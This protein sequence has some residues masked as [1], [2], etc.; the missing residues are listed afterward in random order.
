MEVLIIASAAF[1]GAIIAALA[2][3]LDSQASF[4]VRKFLSSAL[5]AVLAAVGYA[6]VYHY[7]ASGLTT[8]DV[9]TAFLGG[10]GVDV[11]GNRMTGYLVAKLGR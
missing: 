3:Y 8:L 7:S 1:A 10:A 6:V 2:G 9:A 11:L 5:R 4:N